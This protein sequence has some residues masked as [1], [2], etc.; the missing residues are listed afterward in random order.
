M[1]RDDPAVLAIRFSKVT[2]EAIA[3]EASRTM[4]QSSLDISE[5]R[6]PDLKESSPITGC[7]VDVGGERVRRVRVQFG[8][9]FIFLPVGPPSHS[10]SIR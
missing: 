2:V 10:S 3:P 4:L 8:G 1:H 7:D 5:A 9:R 6:R